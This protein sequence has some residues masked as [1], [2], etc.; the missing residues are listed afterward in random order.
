VRT[1]VCLVGFFLS[2]PL[3]AQSLP[4]TS[5]FAF[6]A[7]SGLNLPDWDPELADS[8]LLRAQV[9][10]Q[11]GELSHEDSLGRGPGLQAL[12]EGLPPGEY[13]EV[14]GAGADFGAVWAAWLASPPHRKVLMTPGWTRWGSG[15]APHGSTRVWVLRLWRP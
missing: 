13:G 8:A 2:L 3:T 9:L 15:S 7:E 4:Q 11:A 1:A 14:L 12:S 6:R 10:A 5:L